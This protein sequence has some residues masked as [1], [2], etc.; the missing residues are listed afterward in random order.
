MATEKVYV[1]Y[2][3]WVQKKVELDT[4]IVLTL[5]G[6]DIDENETQYG[7]QVKVWHNKEVPLA[8][9]QNVQEGDWVKAKCEEA[10]VKDRVFHNV[11]DL[12]KSTPPEGSVAVFTP[13]APT[14]NNKY[15]PKDDTTQRSIERQTGSHDAAKMMYALIM[16]GEVK[17][18]NF[19][20]SHAMVSDTVKGMVHDIPDSEV[21]TIE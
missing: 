19:R 11:E 9:A 5:S 14:S 4:S 8:V 10:R 1:E 7:F 18:E 12:I 3:G 2:E 17:L 15:Q 21:I 20:S 6:P 13:V 16:M